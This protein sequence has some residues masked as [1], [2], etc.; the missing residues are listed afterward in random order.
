[1]PANRR[2]GDGV[3]RTAV[4]HTRLDRRWR[5][6]Q[7]PEALV[8]HD[9]TVATVGLRLRAGTMEPSM[10]FVQRA[11]CLVDNALEWT[12]FCS[13]RPTLAS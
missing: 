6:A 1:M 2:R 12:T 4:S 5:L 7:P 3:L 8:G 9:Q 10:V 11:S 13:S